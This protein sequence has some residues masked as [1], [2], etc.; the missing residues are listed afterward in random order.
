[1][2]KIT[3]TSYSTSPS[4]TFQDPHPATGK[5][6]HT[7]AA[8]T[9]ATLD[10]END[11]LKRMAPQF[12]AFENGNYGVIAGGDFTATGVDV[13]G[14]AYKD[15]HGQPDIYTTSVGSITI[16]GETG[17]VAKGVHL[18]GQN[19]FASAVLTAAGAPASNT[20]VTVRSLL[21]GANGNNFTIVVIDSAD[22]GSLACTHAHDAT[23]PDRITY[24]VDFHGASH[25]ATQ[26]TS[27]I[28]AAFPNT[29]YAVA[30][31][32]GAGSVALQAATALTGGAGN[33]VKLTAGGADCLFTAF[34]ADGSTF[35]F[36][37]PDLASGPTDG[38]RA[39]LAYWCEDRIVSTL[40]FIT[41]NA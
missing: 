18:A 8:G 39:Q 16:G 7:I 34:A 2:P 41:T 29:L 3:V 10:L 40:T 20:T 33:G 5:T 28:N 11:V 36:S 15:V 17:I 19:T 26:V 22:A 37:T 4:F 31:G 35:T 21:P 24:T 14:D 13:F 25:T 6:V 38:G 23:V 9:S 27:V 30:G 32:N 12:R 1:M